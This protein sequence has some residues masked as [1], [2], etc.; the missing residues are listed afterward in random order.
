MRIAV[1]RLLVL[2]ALLVLTP[3]VRAQGDLQ[4]S[5]KDFDIAPHWIYDDLPKAL[6]EAKA[7]GKPVLVVLRCVPCPPGRNLDVQVMRPDKE[8][9]RLEK[10]FV[11]VRVVQTRGLDL[12][13]FQFDYD[14]SWA[15]IFMNADQVIYGRY[16]TR[17]TSGPNSDSHIS[18]AG[19]R[20]ALERAL[21][22]HKGYPG[23]KAQLAGNIGKEPEYPVPERIPGLQD[24]VKGPT[25]KQTCIHCHMVREYAL[26]D[27]WQQKRLSAA[28]LWV[29]P[30][31]DN[32]GLTMDIDDGLRV[33]KVVPGSLAAKAGLAAG[34]ELLTLN[35]QPLTSMADIQW[36]LH[37]T[38]ADAKLAVKL[39]RDGQTHDKVVVLSGKWKESDIAWRAS[40]W[41]GL[42]QGLQVTPLSA[43]QKQMRGIPEDGLALVV[44][45]LFGK[46]GPLL[47]KAGLKNGD[48]IVAIDGKTVA[49]TETEFLVYLRL[50]HGPGDSV[51]FTVLRKEG[52]EDLK[53]PMW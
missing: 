30:M 43:A 47:Q 51:R 45:G 44:K 13:V 27:K 32:L 20:K 1:Q 49:M 8:L 17:V 39:R 19:F 9:E 23:N 36:V 28:D 42:R 48:I 11:C 50:T 6:S 31:P 3:A 25:T 22:L 2:G 4:Q 37:N 35:G 26:R 5:L 46:G 10:Q 21:E 24:R 18:L 41:Y 34:D 52:R 14:L 53:I 15:A 33:K 40:S 7:T 38:P 29:F 16:G 12:K